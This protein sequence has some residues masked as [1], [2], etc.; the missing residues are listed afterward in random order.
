MITPSCEVIFSVGAVKS[1]IQENLNSNLRPPI[2]IRFNASGYNRLAGF[3]RCD[4]G[5][6]AARRSN[7]IKIC[8]SICGPVLL[9]RRGYG[10]N[11]AKLPP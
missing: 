9:Q 3:E 1:L 4:E 11:T 5:L 2:L 6:F 10:R 7:T 8:L